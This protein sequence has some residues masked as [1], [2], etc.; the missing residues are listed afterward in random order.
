MKRLKGIAV[1]AAVLSM[2]GASS[3]AIAAPGALWTTT[4]SGVSVNA[5][6]YANKGDVYLNGGP[7]HGNG[8]GLPDGLYYVQVTAPDGTLLG[9]SVGSAR[10]TPI[11]VVNGVMVSLYQLSAIVVKASNGAP[12]YDNTPNHGKEYKVWVSQ[13]SAFPNSKSKT[14]NFKAPDDPIVIPG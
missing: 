5:N 13:D 2:V 10:P 8:Q 9:S 11:H 6:I 7:Q 12:G 3:S 1:L 4:A 14:D